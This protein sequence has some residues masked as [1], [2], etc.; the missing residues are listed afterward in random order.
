LLIV[1]VPPDVIVTTPFARSYPVPVDGLTVIPCSVRL[2]GLFALSYTVK[3]KLCDV[4][5][6]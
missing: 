4:L 1:T 3:L 2:T 5:P 6:P